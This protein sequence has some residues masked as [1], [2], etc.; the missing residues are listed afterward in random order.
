MQSFRKWRWLV[1]LTVLAALP[2]C[3]E[4]SEEEAPMKLPASVDNSSPQAAKAG[5]APPMSDAPPPGGMLKGK[6]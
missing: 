2:A 5:A 1:G 6:R 4:K 3:G